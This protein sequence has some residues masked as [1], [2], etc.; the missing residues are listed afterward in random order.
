MMTVHFRRDSRHLRRHRL[1]VHAHLEAIENA[2][3]KNVLLAL[4]L[5]RVEPPVLVC[6]QLRKETQLEWIQQQLQVQV[7]GIRHNMEIA[8]WQGMRADPEAQG[9]RGEQQ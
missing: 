9:Q 1:P 4:Q 7:I 6:V 5:A 8:D 2:A 3:R